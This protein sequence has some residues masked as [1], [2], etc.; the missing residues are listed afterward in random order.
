[1]R[2]GRSERIEC[3]AEY[4]DYLTQLFG[5]NR[6]GKPMFKIAWGQSD[7]MD[8]A[9]PRGYS[10]MLTGHNQPCWMIQRWR[11]PELFGT[12]AIY[13]ALNADAETGLCMLGE[14]PHFGLY[15]TLVMLMRKRYDPDTHELA[16]DTLPLEWDLIEKVIPV[17]EVA[18][19]MTESERR[20]A[21]KAV[22]RA[23]NDAMVA[24]IEDRM[25]DSLPRFY[26]ATSHASRLNKTSLLQQKKDRIERVWRGLDLRKARRG[27]YQGQN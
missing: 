12:P 18:E 16:I 11:P 23:E 21:V 1:M 25:L 15:E 17:L 7:A 5:V 10:Q 3:P 22:E 4:Q 14:Y 24:D 19:R 13:Y 26:D 8:Y 2:I 6:F 27:F 20:E 9:T